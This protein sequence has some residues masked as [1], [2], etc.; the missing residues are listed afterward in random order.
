M[1]GQQSTVMQKI[2]RF[3]DDEIVAIREADGTVYVPIRP[4]CN[5]LGI[6]WSSQ[7]ERINRDPILSDMSRG[8][9]VTRTPAA[10]GA[11]EMT[12]LPLDMMHGWLFGIQANRVKPEVREKLL[13]Y[14]RDCYRVL[15]EAFLHD[16][17]THRPE[18]QFEHIL[19]SDSPSVQAYQM[20]KAVMQ[21]ARQQVVIESRLLSAEDSIAENSDV[22][23]TLD[24]RVQLLEAQGGDKTR[25][26]D[27]TQ[28]SRI[29]Q[30]VKTIALELGKRTGRNE[31]GGV[32]GE[33]YRRFEIPGYKQLP[34]VKFEEAIHFLTDWYE[35]LTGVETPF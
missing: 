11:Q 32:Y 3:Y 31:F 12:C 27:N 20:A 6:R 22:I 23:S 18:P 29:S 4:I 1:D 7:Y 35:S 9:L 26:I 5:L 25:Q 16:E 30:A 13:T 8:V 28:A 10:G 14:Q 21:M 33:L 34:S 15:S 2:I 24:S 19:P 17:I